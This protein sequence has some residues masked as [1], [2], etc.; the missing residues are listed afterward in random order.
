MLRQA[1]LPISA[2]RNS[3]LAVHKQCELD[4]ALGGAGGEGVG[5]NG[6]RWEALQMELVL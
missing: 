2:T 6:I 3:V 4:V 1:I 5:V